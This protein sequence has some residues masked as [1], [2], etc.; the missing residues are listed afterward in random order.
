MFGL[1]HGPELIIVLVIALIVLGPGKIPE[2]AQ[3]LG[4]GLRELRQASADLQKTFDV[5]E[6]I[7]PSPPTPPPP[8]APEP[9]PIEALRPSVQAEQPEATIIKP[10]RVRKPRVASSTVGAE[11]AESAIMS[12]DQGS[13]EAPAERPRPKRRPSKKATEAVSIDAPA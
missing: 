9:A 4:K 13:A 10:K 2:I 7:N 11:A 5:N 3:M 12:S 8:P 1:G 6:L